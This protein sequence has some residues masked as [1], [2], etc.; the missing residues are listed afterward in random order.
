MLKEKLNILIVATSPKG[1]F[2]KLGIIQI[3]MEPEKG[4]IR[5]GQIFPDNSMI[6]DRLT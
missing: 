2:I 6:A 4:N 1:P 5:S 3:L